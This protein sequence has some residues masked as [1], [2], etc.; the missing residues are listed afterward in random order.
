MV[1]RRFGGEGSKVGFKLGER[2]L[3]VSVPEELFLLEGLQIIKRG[4]TNDVFKFIP[5]VAEITFVEKFVNEKPAV[6]PE[7][8]KVE[9]KVE[10]KVEAT[11]KAGPKVE[12]KAKVEAKV[13]AAEPAPRPRRKK[14]AVPAQTA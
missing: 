13:A 1:D 10:P 8:E 9:P 12:A 11:E 2:G 5:T 3:E 14:K 6:K 7:A 4:I